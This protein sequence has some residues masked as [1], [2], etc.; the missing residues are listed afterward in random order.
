MEN[1]KDENTLS[2]IGSINCQFIGTI[3]EVWDS[4][5]RPNTRL[6]SL[7]NSSAIDNP[8]AEADDDDDDDDDDDGGGGPPVASR[9]T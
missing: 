1:A 7:N 2:A 8:T 5:N 9:S 4:P 6:N 3:G